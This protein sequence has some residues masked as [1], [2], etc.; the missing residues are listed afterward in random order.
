MSWMD[1]A[2]AQIQLITSEESMDEEH[3]LKITCCKHSAARTALEQAADASPNFKLVKSILRKMNVPS[4]DSNRVLVV[5]ER[6]LKQLENGEIGTSKIVRLRPHKKKAILCAL[7]NLPEATG[8]AYTIDNVRKGF[9]AN[10]QLDLW[11]NTLPCLSN[12]LGGYKE[13]MS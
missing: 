5:L 7:G 2:N 9:I 11:S 4:K 8:E 13:Y 10:G 1:G 3:K 6:L 12:L